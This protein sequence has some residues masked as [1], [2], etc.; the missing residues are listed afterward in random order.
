MSESSPD[1]EGEQGGSGPRLRENMP[2]FAFAD[3]FTALRLPLA[4]AFVLLPETGWRLTCLLT[5]GT[6]DFLDGIL[7]RRYGSSRFGAFLDPLADKLFMVA[8]FSMVAVSGDLTLYE[9]A[10]VLL[11]DI[12]ATGAFVGTL[13]S[14]RASSIPA[15]LGGKAVTLGQLL[16]L[17]AFIMGSPMIRPLAWATSAVGLYAIWDY[18]QAARTS[19][20][21][22]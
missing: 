7:A 3:L 1:P 10:G 13:I 2:R 22:L 15:R 16:T 9:I 4:V 19:L 17:F 11:R 18:R 20:Q 6:S 8:A 5:A 21:R 14:G 12:V